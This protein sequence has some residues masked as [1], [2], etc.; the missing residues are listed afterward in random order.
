MDIRT[1]V[2]LRLRATLDH[3]I[4]EDFVTEILHAHDYPTSQ[5]LWAA[6][7]AVI[8]L[9]PMDLITPVVG[10]LV[11]DE[12]RMIGIIFEVEPE[13]RMLN[14]TDASLV[15]ISVGECASNSTKKDLQHV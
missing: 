10:N 11:D 8:E 13:A 6:V 3:M 7:K 4:T 2:R 1:S 12:G 15:R 5:Q 9:Q 14:S